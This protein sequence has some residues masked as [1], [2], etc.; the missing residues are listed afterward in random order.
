MTWLPM[1]PTATMPLRCPERG[2]G[3]TMKVIR[4]PRV[5]LVGRQQCNDA[6]T[7][8]FLTDYGLSWQ[9]DTEVGAE[10]L[11]EAGG[12]VCYLSFGKGRR[13]NAE[14]IG[15]LIAREH[16][17]VL[18]HAVTPLHHRRRI[19]Q[20]GHELVR[21]RAGFGLVQLSQRYVDESDAAFVVPDVI[22]E[23]ERAYAVMNAGHR[24]CPG[25]L[26]GAGGD[27]AGPL[28]GRPRPDA[29]AQAGAAGGAVGAGG[30]HRDHHLR[31]GGRAG[32]APLHRAAGRRR[33]RDRD[34]QGGARD[35]APT[36]REAPSIF[37][38]YRIERL[39]D[40]T[41]VART[42]HRKV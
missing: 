36:C 27:T 12:R 28:P 33:G 32:A 24:G 6:G 3:T 29:C 17:S 38:D 10:R 23:D 5:Y 31:H 20:T 21:H 2:V 26:S 40:G 39:P 4:E 11:V 8:C 9:T 25:C 1:V 35:P 15:N 16:G 34:T 22:A 37:G 19:P 7:C 42:D 30:R 41:E 13:S 18:E 14:Y